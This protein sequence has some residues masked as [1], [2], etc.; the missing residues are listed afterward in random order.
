M[1]RFVS[2]EVYVFIMMFQNIII[3]KI[4]KYRSAANEDMKLNAIFHNASSIEVIGPVQKFYL[5]CVAMIKHTEHNI[6]IT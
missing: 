4:L 5:F 1:G 3:F 6:Y 2:K